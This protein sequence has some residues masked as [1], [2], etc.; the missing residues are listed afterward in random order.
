MDR[1]DPNPFRGTAGM[2]CAFKTRQRNSIWHSE[3][4]SYDFP[5]TGYLKKPSN[6]GDAYYSEVSINP[7]DAAKAVSSV[8]ISIEYTKRPCIEDKSLTLK[9]RPVHFSQNSCI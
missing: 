8:Y 7:K 2:Y 5:R 4:C 6:S 9:Y 1:A 3:N